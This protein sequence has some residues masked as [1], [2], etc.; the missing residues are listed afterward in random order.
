MNDSNL[1]LL[2]SSP[3]LAGAEVELVEELAREMR[4]K[5]ALQPL[6]DHYDY[7]LIDCPPSLGLLT[8]NG[9]VAA[10]DGVLVPN[11]RWAA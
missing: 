11:R 6:E 2:P 8:V 3:S 1:H 4:L 9:L 10:K 5:K 7:I